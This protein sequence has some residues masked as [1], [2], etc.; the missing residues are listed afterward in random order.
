MSRHSD[1]LVQLVSLSFASTSSPLDSMGSTPETSFGSDDSHRRNLWTRRTGPTPSKLPSPQLSDKDRAGSET[2]GVHETDTSDAEGGEVDEVDEHEINRA[3]QTTWDISRGLPRSSFASNPTFRFCRG[4][5]S[6]ERLHQ[7]LS[8]H[9]GLLDHFENLRKDW[10]AATG[11]LVLRIMPPRPLHGIF[12]SLLFLAIEKEL[13]RVARCS[14]A[15]RPFRD[16]LCPG[17]ASAIEKRKRH[18]RVSQF[19]KSPDGQWLYEGELYPPFLY[20]VAY[21]QE[22]ENLVEKVCDRI[23]VWTTSRPAC[24]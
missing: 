1:R 4:Q 10:V 3:Y 8:E 12:K 11:V 17:S 15:L 22:D 13:D 24:G 20:E 2:D 23:R 7:K 14:P 16:K 21:S 5:R 9:R 19:E 18:S 6:Y